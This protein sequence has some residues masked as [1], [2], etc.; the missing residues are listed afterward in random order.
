MDHLRSDHFNVPDWLIRAW[1]DAE[2][3]LAKRFGLIDLSGT[4]HQEKSYWSRNL[5]LPP[6][7]PDENLFYLYEAVVS[8]HK[9]PANICDLSPETTVSPGIFPSPNSANLLT[10]TSTDFGYVITI[11][12]SITRPWKL[13][14]SD[15]LTILQIER[16]RWCSD[17]NNLLT[18]LVTNGIP[19]QVLNPNVL[20]ASPFLKHPGP[21]LHPTGKDPLLIDYFAYRHGL[22]DFLSAYPRARAAAL[23]AGGIL[24]RL[25]VDVLPLPSETEIVGPF[26]HRSCISRNIDGITYWTP[27]L[28]EQEEQVLVGVYRW[29][30]SKPSLNP[31]PL[32]LHSQ[33]TGPSD[34]PRDDSWWPKPQLW[35]GSGLDFGAWAPLDEDWY[36]KRRADIANR[37]A[38]CV[39][40]RRWRAYIKFAGKDAANFLSNARSLAASFLLQHRLQTLPSPGKS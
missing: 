25:S 2:N 32:M 6:A 3:F 23:C 18:H 39:Q 33:P 30:E 13:L 26:D 27:R 16:E 19:F 28:T 34:N 1:R 17:A 8:R 38:S 10:L 36:Q 37:T 31:P 24:W 15:P 9:W 35:A 29:A 22:A 7:Q 20:R 14:I 4:L 40:S 21:T 12:D 5:G 11:H